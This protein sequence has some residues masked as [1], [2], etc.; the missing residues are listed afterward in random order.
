MPET[1]F[2]RLNPLTAV[3]ELQRFIRR[4]ALVIA[5][6]IY[7]VLNGGRRDEIS[8]ELFAGAVGALVVIPALLRY[9]SYGYAVQDGKLLV[10]SGIFV[11][12]LRTIPLDR[13]Q[14]IN[15]KRDWLHRILG[16][17]E[18]EIETAAGAKPEATISSLNEEQAHILQAQLLGQQARSY[19]RINRGEERLILYKPTLYELFLVGV[20]E[21]R[22][23]A[24]IAAVAGLSFFQP[25]LAKTLESQSGSIKSSHLQGA[26]VFKFMILGILAFL[27]FG[28]L[29]SII[30]TFFKY[31]EFELSERDGKL[32]RAYGLINHFENMIPVNRI[33]TVHIDQNLFQK[34]LGVCK[35]YAA[36]AGGMA[37]ESKGGEGEGSQQHIHSAPLLTPVLRDPMREHLLKST[38]P[39]YD[40]N[41]P[42]YRPVSPKTVWRHLRSAVW[43]VLLVG[44][45][46]FG[47]VT[48]FRRNVPDA[49]KTAP[50]LAQPWLPFAVAALLA[51]LA[52]VA[53]VVYFR[54]MR[55]SESN[56]VIATKTGWFKTRWSFLPMPKIQLTEVTQNPAQRMFG[57]ATVRFSSAALAF[58]HTEIDDIPLD[59][60]ITLA[61]RTHLVAGETRDSLFDGF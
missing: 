40:L 56:H 5:T 17:V 38:L 9:F 26:E 31:Y 45:G 24:I 18:L 60:A 27:V 7:M 25:L 36:T 11:K 61:H 43:P 47:L 12:N 33:Q 48:M 1:V 55:W 50:L 39:K 15:V 8:G 44:G 23:G 37:Y 34:W 59:E 41:H 53:G 29:L 46:L 49:L 2:N 10:R 14:N 57:L 22:A 35:M 21:N 4:F 54:F 19:S 3:I 30:G 6:G 58:K 28:W 51:G 13:I 32:R 16:L 52:L 20:S 42:E